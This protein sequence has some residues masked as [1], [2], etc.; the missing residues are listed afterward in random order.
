MDRRTLLLCLTT[1]LAAPL[2]LG[3]A[4]LPWNL[5]GKK[6]LRIKEPAQSVKRRG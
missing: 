2:L 5:A 3:K 1:F 6:A 4:G